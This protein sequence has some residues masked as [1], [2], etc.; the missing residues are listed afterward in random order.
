MKNTSEM[1][2]PWYKIA[3]TD[4]VN[5]PALLVYPDRIEANI[6]KM[7]E[8]A[9]SADRLRPHVKTHKMAGDHQITD[10]TWHKQIQMCYN[11]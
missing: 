8:I 3:N 10:E 9:G 6:R 2:D 11:I 5:S 1:S 4:E 7:I